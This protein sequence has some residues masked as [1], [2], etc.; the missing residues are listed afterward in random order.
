MPATSKTFYLS[1]DTLKEL[2]SLTAQTLKEDNIAL[3]DAEYL[4]SA[5]EDVLQRWLDRL[6]DGT[7]CTFSAGK[8]L[9]R[10][11]IT[12]SAAGVR[13]NPFGK[14]GDCV[15]SGGNSVQT[16]L[17]NYGLAPSY[18]YVNGENQITIMPK[19]RK[20]NPIIFL[21]AALILGII[22]GLCCHFLPTE[23]RHSFSTVIVE[24]VFNTFIGLLIAFALPMMFLSLIWGIFSIGDTATLGKIGK[25]V[26]GRY[27]GRILFTLLVCL[28]IAIPFFNFTINGGSSGTGDF[29]SIWYLLLNIVPQ[30]LITP[31][32]E[33][34][35]LQIIFLA[36]IAGLAILVLKKKIPVVV[37]FLGQA[38][39]IIQLIMEWITA[40]LPIIVFISVLNLML[41]DVIDDAG[42][43]VTL[44][45][46]LI[47]AV[48]VNMFL[49][50]C[51]VAIFKKVS[52][53]VLLK[54]IAPTFLIA[55][56][57]ASSAAT[58]STNMDCCEKK[59]GIKKHLANF[60]VP[61]GTA[62][63]RPGHALTF[64]CVCLFMANYY[65]VTMSPGWVFSALLTCGLLAL[66]VPPVPGGG[67]ACYTILFLQLGIPMEALAIAVVLEIILDFIATSLNMVA[68]P[69]DLVMVADKLKMLD[70]D[71]L[72]KNH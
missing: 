15:L 17:S 62:F 46:V 66:S 37:Q 1:S 9:G 61:L 11:Y 44:F 51:E 19:R 4:Q 53:K 23:M 7:E 25:K 35:T 56:T 21:C 47:L 60:G 70:K 28:A 48:I 64:F 18:H 67:I 45:I 20:I 59:M 65:G 27:L 52:P 10:H 6:G 49:M 36:V 43:F 41:K 13:V 68:V 50:G 54:K 32:S 29:Q 58:F 22:V 31:F 55:L 16:T 14:E 34:N 72:R 57:T 5:V 63:S 12:F 69:T 38:N 26:V 33:G 71:V 2:S 39:S 40:F 24:P 42:Q 30:N 3:E 8:K